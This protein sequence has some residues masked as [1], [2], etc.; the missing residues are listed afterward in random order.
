[1]EA[2]R[3]RPAALYALDPQGNCYVADGTGQ[4]ILSLWRSMVAAGPFAPQHG[5]MTPEAPRPSPPG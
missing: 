3:R 1:M 2:G 5:G 4:S